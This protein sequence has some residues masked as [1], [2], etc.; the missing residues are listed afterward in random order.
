MMTILVLIL[1]VVSFRYKKIFLK[2]FSLFENG[3]CAGKYERK[4]SFLVEYRGQKRYIKKEERQNKLLNN[5][6]SMKS[7]VEF[8][9][10]L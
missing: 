9:L 7:V 3:K 4:L 2:F 10:F 8:L 5:F 1:T 6:I